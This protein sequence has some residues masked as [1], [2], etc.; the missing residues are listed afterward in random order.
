MKQPA[1][2]TTTTTLAE[3]GGYGQEL[4]MQSCKSTGGSF[5]CGDLLHLIGV[6]KGGQTSDDC[7]K[8]AQK[9]C[10]SQPGC[11]GVSTYTVHYTSWCDTPELKELSSPSSW[12][13]T[14]KQPAPASAPFMS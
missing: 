8:A 11:Y 12:V 14:M 9:N 1:A 10:D 13:T 3:A 4:T 7:I 2:T 6:A 5:L